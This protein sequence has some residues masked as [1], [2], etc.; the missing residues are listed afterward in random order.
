MNNPVNEVALNNL[1]Q[2]ALHKL[3]LVGSDGSGTST[4]FKQVKKLKF[5]FTIFFYRLL[6]HASLQIAWFLP[7]HT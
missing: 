3:L 1:D 7:I 5:Q 2:K 6:Y 4:I